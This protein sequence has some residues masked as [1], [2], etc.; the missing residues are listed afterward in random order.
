[1][2]RRLSSDELTHPILQAVVGHQRPLRH[3][4]GE[5][6]QCRKAFFRLDGVGDAASARRSR[7][8][9]AR[10]QAGGR[11]RGPAARRC[12]SGIIKR[13]WMFAR[14]WLA[15]AMAQPSFPG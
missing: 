8:A 10:R 9:P 7:Q 2:A 13:E 14:A 3:S 11:S 4:G 6:S 12:I 5:C 1:V 15:A